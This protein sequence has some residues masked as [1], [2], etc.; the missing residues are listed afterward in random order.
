MNVS[1]VEASNPQLRLARDFVQ[2]TGQHIFLTGKAGTG[3]TTFLHGLKNSI[4]KRLIV[5]APTGVAAINAGGVTLHSFFQMPFGPIVPGSDVQQQAQQR[6]FNKEKINIIK[7][8]DLLVIDEISMVRADLLDGVDAVLR[9]YRQ[10]PLPFGGVQLLMIGDLHQLSPVIRDDEWNLLKPWYDTG[11]FFSSNAL[12]Q[13]GMISIELQHIYRQ[14]DAE[15]IRLL[16]RVRDNCLDDDVLQQLNQRHIASFQPDEKDNYITLTTHNRAADTI[17]G[18]HLQTL[19]AKPFVFRASIDGD[20]P[21]HSYPTAEELCLKKGAQVMFVRNDNSGDKRYFNGKIGKITHI[22]QQHIS[23]QCPD[24]DAAIVVEPV[25]WEN[26]KYFLDGTSA[27]ITAEV[28]GKFTQFPLRAAW[29]ITIH[30]SQGLTFERA[31]IDA[32]AAFAHGQVYVALS[33][34]KS[35]EG[36]VLSTPISRTA[37]KTDTAV[38][39]FT[40]QTDNNPA[41]QQQLEQAM[42]LYQQGLLLECFNFQSLAESL[43]KFSR[44]L[45]DAAH[46]IHASS[47]DALAT[48]EQQVNAE[49]ISVAEKFT[50]Q[51][52]SLFH[53]DKMPQTDPS[54]Q[55]RVQKASCYF[56]DKLQSGQ[57][58]LLPWLDSFGF[59]TDNRELRQQINKACSEL[60]QSLRVKT[61]ALLSCKSGFSSADY[62]HALDHAQIDFNPDTA[63]AVHQTDTSLHKTQ[64]Q[65]LLLA[66]KA[67][68]AQQ[69][70]AEGLDQYRILRQG[71]LMQISENL[72]TTMAKL[73]AIKG[74][75]KR[76]AKKYGQAIIT[77]VNEYCEA[78][79]G[80]SQ[81]TGVQ[82]AIEK[83]ANPDT[84]KISY[85]LYRQGKSIQQIAKE[86][87]LIAS[88]IE[89]HLAHYVSQ[90]LLN[91]DEL[92]TGEKRAMI[93][94]ALNNK[95]A[96]SI[97]Q[98]KDYLGADF[99]YGEIRLVQESLHKN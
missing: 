11:Y 14:S 79:D 94:N 59:D 43:G 3:K 71:I 26:I 77:L 24:G 45:R 18:Q 39:T 2:H 91:I 50:R 98:I 1:K 78:N 4:P 69:A 87:G 89:G 53:T 9:R 70:K 68:R 47:I 81:S 6:R 17:N 30:K 28:I 29:A 76:S 96:E 34:C 92:V 31:I 99:S 54:I 19:D 21:Q 12:K 35:L 7:S 64:H 65:E 67:W 55:Q 62:L 97:K 38:K 44:Q 42:V 83:S 56:S 66:L 41:T 16:N 82:S 72:P 63:G 8:L 90:G 23:V 52:Q 57:T 61:A 80:V 33:R 27:E 20:Y 49:I 60:R 86:R 40:T 75:G 84:R 58:A 73:L 37:V 74:L 36:M 5:T 51:L 15:F 25:T 22:D 93:E 85:Q 48:R 88:T 32:N 95:G 13:A 46:L 10:S